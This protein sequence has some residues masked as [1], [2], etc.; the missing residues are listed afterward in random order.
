MHNMKGRLLEPPFHF[1]P[2]F[3]VSRTI[4]FTFFSSAVS[5]FQT[6]ILRCDPWM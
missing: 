3:F 4:G 6:G 2:V 1:G 5:A